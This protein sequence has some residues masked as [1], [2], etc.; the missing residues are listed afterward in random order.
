MAIR[1]PKL[2]LSLRAKLSIALGSAALIPLV[3][4]SAVGGRV[5]LG[6]LERNLLAQTRQTSHI[7][8]NLLLRQ[9]Q[10]LS[11]EAAKLAADPELHELLALE[12]SLIGGYLQNYTEATEA[13]L[14]EVVLRDRSVAARIAPH[15]RGGMTQIACR[16]ES[17]ALARALDYE[18]YLSVA[19]LGGR[20]VIQA[21]APIVDSMFV[22]RGA[23]IMTTPLDEQMSDYIKSVVRADIGFLAGRLP[24]ASTYVDEAGRRLPGAQPPRELALRVLGGSTQETVERVGGQDY[25]IAYTPLQT[26]QGRR[27]GMMSVALSREGFRRA[28]AS[29]VRSLVFGGAMSLLLALVLAYAF[30]KRITIPLERLHRSTQAIAAGDLEQE[31]VVE[32]DDEI[33]DLAG[34]FR[35]MTGALREHQDRLAARVREILTLHQIGRAVS[36]VLGLDQVLRLV[37]NEVASVL[38]A[39]RGAILL[40]G[41]QGGLELAGEFNLLRVAD[42]PH[43]PGEWHELAERVLSQHA[44]TVSGTLLAVPLETRERGVGALVMA[45][46]ETGGAFSEADLRLVVTFADQAA[47]AI[48]N[49][50]LYAEVSAFS[51]ELEETVRRR[52]AQLTLMNEELGR[53]LADLKSTQ[54][55]L[56]EQERMAGLGLLVAGVAH[57]INTPAGAIQGSAQMLGQ[58]LE[59]LVVRLRALVDCGLPREEAT[60]LLDRMEQAR[61]SLQHAGLMPPTEMRRKARELASGL[62]AKGIADSRRLAKRL[63]EAGAGPIVEDVIRLSGRVPPDLVVGIVEDLSFL[64]RSSLSIQA[65]ISALVRLVRAL[66]SYAHS[67]QQEAIVDVDIH[68]GLETTLTILHNV[69]R[70]GITVTRSFA[71]L[72]RVPVYQDELNQVWTNLI[73]N[74]AQ[75]MNGKGELAIETL[76]REAE[77]GVRIVDNGPGIPPEIMPRI[78]E[79]FFTTKPPGEGTGLGL[80]ISQRIVEK[81]GGRIEVESR[82]G[83]TTFTV[84]LPLHRPPR[85]ESTGADG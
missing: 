26:V 44:A 9:V 72:P 30:G 47:T 23:V 13:G 59:R 34:A 27:I 85:K 49:A 15:L 67:D 6:R 28:Q 7:A 52:T 11:R 35:G 53:A 54:A 10:R 82:P 40:A 65:A 74:A 50:R 62:E 58:T 12:P 71:Q 46:R 14:I 56:V 43:V 3:A 25:A 80:G 1:L 66:K 41:K 55:L 77:I 38:G 76:Q 81:H 39:E 64:E 70:Y 32:T 57:E 84:W 20:L 17:E 33:G 78:F 83:R 63:L 31:V 21:S 51:A 75:A 37:V 8:V 24:V 22:L 60:A 4:V 45:R 18:R 16:P 29:A 73:H 68:D 79:P 48:E 42:V 36:S 5:A 61:R 2:H 69:L 19:V